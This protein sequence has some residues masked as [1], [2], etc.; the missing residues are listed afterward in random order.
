MYISVHDHVIEMNGIVF[1][2]WASGSGVFSLPDIEAISVT[3]G[4][5]GDVAFSRTGRKGGPVVAQ[6]LPG[7]ETAIALA[8]QA[9]IVHNGGIIEWNGSII[10]PRTGEVTYLRTGA[11]SMYPSGQTLGNAE[12][13]IQTYTWIYKNIQRVV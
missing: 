8:R 9:A 6:L 12:V 1:S 13:A 3:Y 10:N 11:L 5:D 4:G 7:T 2:G